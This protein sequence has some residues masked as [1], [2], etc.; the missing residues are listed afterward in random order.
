MYT[1][2]IVF[3][4]IRVAD[5]MILI[6]IVSRQLQLRQATIQQPLDLKL[7][8]HFLQSTIFQGKGQKGHENCCVRTCCPTPLLYL[9][10][11]FKP[12]RPVQIP[13]QAVWILIRWLIISSGSTLFALLFIILIETIFRTMVLTRF[14]DGRVDQ[15]L[16][17][18]RIKLT[19]LQSLWSQASKMVQM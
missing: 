16:R 5:I 8:T 2:S 9:A 17:D 3:K 7:I 11:P 6:N 19:I 12:C 1:P 4:L 10:E 14:K 15:T 18:E 13:M